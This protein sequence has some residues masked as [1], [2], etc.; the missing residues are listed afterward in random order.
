MTLNGFPT[1]V[2]AFKTFCMGSVAVTEGNT[3]NP[4]VIRALKGVLSIKRELLERS[5]TEGLML[6]RDDAAFVRALSEAESLVRQI[7]DDIQREKA[8]RILGL[9]RQ[10]NPFNASDTGE[11]ELREVVEDF[12]NF[13]DQR[14]ADLCNGEKHAL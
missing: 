7:V 3:I 14:I 1:S 8:R 13:T 11:D 2:G 12:L 6:Q 4:D 5:L 9:I 10:F